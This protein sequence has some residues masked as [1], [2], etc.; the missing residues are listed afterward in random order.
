MKLYLWT[1][2]L[3]FYIF[4]LVFQAFKNVKL[5]LSSE[6]IQ[7]HTSVLACLSGLTIP[8]LLPPTSDPLLCSLWA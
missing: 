8:K 4:L 2:T 6:A 3:K 1:P 7:I 5:I